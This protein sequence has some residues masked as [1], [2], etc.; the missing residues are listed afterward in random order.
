M[1]LGLPGERNAVDSKIEIRT[2]GTLLSSL[3]P[4]EVVASGSVV[5]FNGETIA[6]I[7]S[8]EGANFIFEVQLIDAALGHE[9]I[10]G[11]PSGIAM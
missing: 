10:K 9:L 3:A 5:I 7:L 1:G 6:I 2:A 4:L 11:I 8:E